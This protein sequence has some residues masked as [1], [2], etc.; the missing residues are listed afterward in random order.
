MYA[1]SFRYDDPSLTRS[2]GRALLQDRKSVRKLRAALDQHASPAPKSARAAAFPKLHP[3]DSERRFER[4]VHAIRSCKSLPDARRFRSEVASQLKRD[5][6]V[7]VQDPVYIRRLNVGKEIVEQRIAV[8]STGEPSQRSRS[9]I[10]NVQAL[11]R[12][13]L[14]HA[15]LLDVL[16]DPAGLSYF[17]EFMDRRQQMTAVQ[18]W[19]VV[20][21]LRNPLEDAP[22]DDDRSETGVLAWTDTDRDDLEQLNQAYLCKPELHLPK[23]IRDAVQLFF[24]QGPNATPAQHYKA[25]RAILK[26]QICVLERMQERH[27]PEFGKS[28]LFFKYLTSDDASD[29]M[30]SSAHSPTRRS[31]DSQ[32][33]RPSAIVRT[34]SAFVTRVNRLR[35]TAASNSDLRSS[36]PSIEAGSPLRRSLD[37]ISAFDEVD[38]RNS[39]DPLSD[40]IQSLDTMGDLDMVPAGPDVK[41]VQALEVALN[42]IVE[43]KQSIDGS[44][45]DWPEL[46][47]PTPKASQE[48]DPLQSLLDLHDRGAGDQKASEKP[49]IASLGLVNTSSRIGVFMDDDLFSDEAK[50][51]EDERED[52][53]END[54]E[55]GQELK[56]QEAVPGDLGLDEAIVAL[57]SDIE[58]LSAQEG[59]VDSLTMKAE[60]TNTAAELR[61]LRKSKA[62]LQ[63]EMRRKELQRQQYMLQRRD[64]KLYGRATIRIKSVMVGT[65]EDGHEYGVYLVEVSRHAGEQML[66]ATWAVARRYSQFHELNR[67]LRAQY[68]SVR[69]L[70]FPRRRMMLKLQQD[71]L[72]KRRM[73]LEK[74]LQELLR[75]PDVC[76]SREL[77]AFLSQRAITGPDM[78]SSASSLSQEPR[79]LMSRFYDSFTSGM[80][81]VIGNIPVL[82]QLSVAGQSLF[83]AAAQQL[84]VAPSAG[85]SS[86]AAQDPLTTAEAE[87]ELRAYES[88]RE[89]EPFVKPICDVF[90]EVFELN[91]ENN[92][93]RGRAVVVIL[94]QLLGGTIERKV[95][96]NAR[97]L[98]D[99]AMLMRYIDFL[100]EAVWPDGKLRRT[101]RPVRTP[102]ERARTRTDAKLVLAAL[103]PEVAGSVVGKSNAQAAA[104]KIFATLNNPILTRH[105]IFTIF[106]EVVSIFRLGG[107]GGVISST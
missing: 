27:F 79:D 54:D 78:S 35:K 43:D 6:L 103:L 104:R 32:N 60:L 80:D 82:D 7:Q 53:E 23:D 83:A 92:W 65:E 77:R 90:L 2:Q 36:T 63:T 47:T 97:A 55:K 72:D 58:K 29:G 8:L 88:N 19:L 40:S 16:R 89:L 46:P 33:R 48:S 9:R 66:A 28:D 30:G 107:Q 12:S 13:R 10:R 5:M 102:S 106:D 98:A 76:R 61:I 38:E 34:S 94:H 91:K 1:P 51:V 45:I 56:I 67:R 50:F 15:T 18:F 3:G 21:G 96:D 44:R 41:V 4:F 95:R 70:D 74:Y 100:R 59:V 68:P 105:L 101:P 62:S 99:E 93:L 22:A 31:E 81:D 87:A 64:N 57:D 52:P 39:A 86:N 14:E 69:Q 42:D 85:V 26:A 17:M 49:S 71:F 84:Q 75:L 20:E 37:G 24:S 25:R 73:A 11:P